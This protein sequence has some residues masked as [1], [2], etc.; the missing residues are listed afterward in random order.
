M[1]TGFRNNLYALVVTLALSAS[2]QWAVAA[3]ANSSTSANNSKGLIV[4]VPPE[5]RVVVPKVDMPENVMTRKIKKDIEDKKHQ[6]IKDQAGNIQYIVTFADYAPKNYPDKAVK[7]SRFADWHDSKVIQLLRDTEAIH[8]FSATHLYSQTMQGFAAFLTPQ[9]ASNLGQDSRVKQ[10]SQSFPVEFSGIWNDYGN[11][12]WG[13]QAVGGGKASNGTATVYVVDS[14]VGYNSDLNVSSRWAAPGSCPIGNY[15]HSTFVAGIIGA[16]GYG[17]IGVDSGVNIA[18]LAY[19]DNSC[20]WGS[21]NTANII[22]AFEE[23]KVRIWGS[24]HVGVVNFSTNFSS[25]TDTLGSSIRGLITPNPSTGYPGAFFV[26]SAGNQTVNQNGDA[27]YYSFNDH[28]PSDGAMVIG[29]MD[30]NGQPVQ[31]LNGDMGFNQESS[32]FGAAL[33]SN[34]GA[35]VDAWAPGKKIQ[36]TWANYS[37]TVGDG[38]SFAAPHV[39]GVAAYLI[40]TT[41]SLDTPGKVENAVRAHMGLN[42]AS[43]YQNIGVKTVNLDGVGYVAQPTVEF[44]INGSPSDSAPAPIGGAPSYIYNSGNGFTLSYD[45]VG[46]KTNGCT[47]TATV[48]GQPWYTAPNIPASYNWEG[49]NILLEPGDYHWQLTCLSPGDATSNTADAYATITAVPLALSAG[50]SVN[51][52]AVADG[53]TMSFSYPQS[54]TLAYDSTNTT[55]CNLYGYN[56]LPGGSLAPWYSIDNFYPSYNWG[57]VTLDPGIYRWDIDCM[58]TN[59]PGSPHATSTLHMYIN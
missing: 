4:T 59:S 5:K 43:D 3:S 50:F 32:N 21:Q 12:P 26:Q 53:A 33:G 47:L 44:K 46:A 16:R 28:L 8:G 45:S 11:R 36:S 17:V 7:D 56:A 35:C 52:S 40:E 27:C 49:A 19:G 13:I 55:S 1:N 38:T 6:P 15:A 54:F 23:A 24:W 34:F 58:N 37:Y 10:M 57:M 48:N 14:G 31:P 30:S 42:G 29:A 51:G 9:Q 2:S 20:V 25:F 39:A 41:P 18:S 22:S